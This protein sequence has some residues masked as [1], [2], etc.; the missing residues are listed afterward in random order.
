MD[1]IMVEKLIEKAKQASERAYCPNSERPIGACLLTN[2]GMIFTGCNIEISSFAGSLGAIEVV[3]SK[4]ISEGANG[5]R[6]LVNYFE[7]ELYF[8]TG[9]EREFMKEF[10]DKTTIVCATKGHY[11]QFQMRELLPFSVKDA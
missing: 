8:P 11:E 9:S 10:V 2:S 7:S 5:I 3:I 6:M 4:A 1:Q